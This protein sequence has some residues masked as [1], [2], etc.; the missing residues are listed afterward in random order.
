MIS[1]ALPWTL[2][3]GILLAASPEFAA[4]GEAQEFT[5]Q[6]RQTVTLGPI[7]PGAKS[8]EWWVSI[9]NDNRHQEILDIAVISAPGTWAVE[10]EPDHGNQF[11]HVHANPKGQTALDLVVEFTLVRES[12]SV[13]L[14]AARTGQLSETQRTLFAEFLRPDAPHMEVTPE[15]RKIADE[16]CGDEKD[17]A[18]QASKL[19]AKVAE[20]ADHYSKDPSKPSCG[21]GDAENCMTAGGGCCTDLHSLFIAL[22]RSRE[23]PARLQMGYRL[24]GK[25]AGKVVDPGYRCWVEY[26]VP[27]C[28]WVPC[29]I[30][31]ADAVAG[32]GLARWSTGLTVERL[33]L[34]EG[35]E[36]QL[37]RGSD[38]RRVNHMSIGYAEVD[39]KP[40]RLLPEGDQPAQLSRKIQFEI[41]AQKTEGKKKTASV[42]SPSTLKRG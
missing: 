11:I 3:A 29:D 7:E 4:A 36:L 2:C 41:V 30:V 23:I 24:L 40:I 22:A 42:T 27:G 1:R 34:N 35:R 8:V 14:T 12:V 31:E 26:F 18:K 37:G 16:T 6:V 5:Y 9:P 25:N 21:I 28:G 33:W 20:L 38:V 15:I 17:V 32:L 19:I 39:G 10:R 13:D